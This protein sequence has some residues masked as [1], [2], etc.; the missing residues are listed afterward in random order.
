MQREPL[1]PEACLI[2]N[3]FWYEPT[4]PGAINTPSHPGGCKHQAIRVLYIPNLLRCND[5]LFRVCFKFGPGAAGNP[6]LVV[7]QIVLLIAAL[8]CLAPSHHLHPG[9]Y[10]I[11]S[12]SFLISIISCSCCIG[13][14][15]L[16]NTQSFII[17][18][19]YD[20]V[21]LICRAVFYHNNLNIIDGFAPKQES[22][23]W[24]IYASL[25]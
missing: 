8:F 22:I 13:C 20:L 2:N 12:S 10:Y 1:I 9:T 6:A 23:V 21:T 19:F 18:G 24:A 16:E 5:S 7:L 15:N 25:L 4:T 3:W 17:Y 14:R 11:R